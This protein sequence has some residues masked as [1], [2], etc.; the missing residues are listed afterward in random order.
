MVKW[1]ARLTC[2]QWMPDRLSIVN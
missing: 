1:V 2:N